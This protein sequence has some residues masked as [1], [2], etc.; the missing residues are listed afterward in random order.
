MV[1]TC[2]E[3]ELCVGNA[4]P[5]YNRTRWSECYGSYEHDRFGTDKEID[6]EICQ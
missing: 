5:R 4:Y 2:A 3:R 1:R 6:G